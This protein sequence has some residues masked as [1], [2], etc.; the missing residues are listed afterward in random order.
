MSRVERPGDMG[1]GVTLRLTNDR[2]GDILV[3]VTGR[4]QF[5]EREA[6]VVCEFVRPGI[7]GGKS[8][9]T[10]AALTALIQAMQDDNVMSPHPN[11]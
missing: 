9:R 8:P 2:D 4:D 5:T 7:G 1:P 3:V 11:G 6:S 10:F